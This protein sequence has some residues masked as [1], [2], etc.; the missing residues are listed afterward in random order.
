MAGRV[1]LPSLEE[2]EK[3]EADRIKYKGDGV[4]F[5]ALYPEFE[6]YFETVRK[7]AGEPIDGKGRL[8]PRWERRW[9]DD[10]KGG[11]QR[12]IEMWRRANEEA[13]RKKKVEGGWTAQAKL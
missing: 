8:L 6:D 12:R 7:L 10:F 1:E 13:W 5:T 3:W 2:Q 11:H 4:P 9:L